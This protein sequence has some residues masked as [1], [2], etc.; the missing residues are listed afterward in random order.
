MSRLDAEQVKQHAGIEPYK[1]RL[2]G[3]HKDGSKYKAKCLWHADSNPSFEV[4]QKDG[5]WLFGCFPCNAK[6][7]VFS[8]V[9]KVDGI[10]FPEALKKIAEE[11]GFVAETEPDFQYDAEKASD[12][13]SEAESYL[14]SRGISIDEARAAGLGVLDFPNPDVGKCIVI[15]YGSQS[16]SGQPVV[17]MRSLA[18]KTKTAKFRHLKDAPS[19][20]LLYGLKDA[21][22]TLWLNPDLWITESELDCLTMRARGYNAIS[23]SSA[24]ACLNKDGS[25]KFN[26][27]ELQKLAEDAERVFLALDQDKAGNECADVFQRVLPVYKTFRVNWPYEKATDQREKIGQKDIGDLFA[28]DPSS[29]SERLTALA[30]EAVNRPPAWRER[31]RSRLEMEPGEIV[32]LVE[33]FLHEGTTFLGGLSGDGKT[34]V[35]LSLAKAIVTGSRFLGRFPVPAKQK[36]LYLVPEMGERA[37]RKRL[38]AFRMPDEGFLCMTMQ[39][40]ILSLDAPDLA[41]AVYAGYTVVML[42]TA[43][44]FSD[45]ESENDNSQNANGLAKA[46]IKLRQMGALAIVAL[47]HSPKATASKNWLSAELEEVLR[48]AGD[49]GAIADI[50]YFVRMLD[51]SK[52]EVGIRCVKQRDFESAPPFTIQGRPWI[53]Q[54]GDFKMLEGLDSAK[55]ELHKA[56]LDRLA[57]AKVK[58]PDASNLE[59][60]RLSGI[61]KNRVKNLLEQLERKGQAEEILTGV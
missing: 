51:E 48:G 23:V 38:D 24:T 37:F 21:T 40:G 34:L 31:F 30:E 13:L 44:R 22:A 46:F 36:V 43:I 49:I 11:T 29:F 27:G 2:S 41:A 50:V 28:A 16:E 10:S 4:Y 5:V 25:F 60:G 59:L 47:H 55:E 26:V 20:N 39:Q 14:A 33:Q 32:W 56:E 53:D 18:P 19:A 1:T 35:A 58:N 57:K 17:K 42:D 8:F 15:P 9:Q 52:T 6:G 7:D 12:R 61:G 54:E 3:L 45:A